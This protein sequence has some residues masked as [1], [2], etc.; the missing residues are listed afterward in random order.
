MPPAPGWDDLCKYAM[1]ALSLGFVV[2][3]KEAAR[4]SWVFRRWSR[5]L[6]CDSLGSVRNAWQPPCQ[7]ASVVRLLDWF[8]GPVVTAAVPVA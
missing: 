3:G 7:R 2:L 5:G 1:E 6:P 8:R 4:W